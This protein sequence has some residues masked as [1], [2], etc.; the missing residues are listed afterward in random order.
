MFEG[1]TSVRLVFEGDRDYVGME[2]SFKT[3]L[4]VNVT[5]N[6]TLENY[7]VGQAVNVEVKLADYKGNPIQGKT[8]HLVKS[9]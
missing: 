3:Y 6:P 9:D 8:I 5:I 7:V 1:E 2:K 4:G